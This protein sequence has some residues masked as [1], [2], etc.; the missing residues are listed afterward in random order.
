MNKSQIEKLVFAVVSEQFNVPVQDLTPKTLLI[1]DL[2][3]DS[4]ALVEFSARLEDTFKTEF[5]DLRYL[6]DK[7]LGKLIEFISTYE[8]LP[9]RTGTD[10]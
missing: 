7:D 1:E 4:A 9:Q 2:G 3:A 8:K 10:G 5:P 6:A